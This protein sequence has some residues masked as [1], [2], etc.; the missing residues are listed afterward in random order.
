LATIFFITKECKHEKGNYWGLVEFG[1]DYGLG[2]MYDSHH[3]VWWANRH[4]YNLLFWWQLFYKLLLREN[5][6]LT[7][8]F[9]MV[10][11]SFVKS[12]DTHRRNMRPFTHAFT[13][14]G[15]VGQHWNAV[16]SG[17]LRS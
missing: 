12:A 4:L 13:P 5:T 10:Y 3:H 16:V 14:K 11:I 17:L 9:S 7:A 2:I 8:G 1:S 6:Y 15:T